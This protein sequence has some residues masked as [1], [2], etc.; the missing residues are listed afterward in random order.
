[1]QQQKDGVKIYSGKTMK[2]WSSAI[3]TLVA[4]VLPTASIAVLTTA[5]TLRDRL[6]YIGGFTLLF[7]MGLMILAK[8]VTRVQIFT[9][10]AA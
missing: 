1:M 4:C 3:V 10:T 9:A 7:A 8:G 2:R 6:L 5:E